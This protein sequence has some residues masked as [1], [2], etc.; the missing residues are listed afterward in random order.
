MHR[1]HISLASGAGWSSVVLDDY[2]ARAG[3]V[4]SQLRILS[5]AQTS[6]GGFQG[7][8]DKLM[9]PLTPKADVCSA[10]V[11]VR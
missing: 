10:L 5:H 3:A 9:S 4:G 1:T 6:D 11:H 8:V 7:A 2:R